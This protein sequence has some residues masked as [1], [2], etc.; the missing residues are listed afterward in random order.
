MSTQHDPIHL[1]TP[2]PRPAARC[3][4]HH[5]WLAACGDCREQHAEVLRGRRRAAADR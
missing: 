1:T 3:L 2:R 4:R 5:V